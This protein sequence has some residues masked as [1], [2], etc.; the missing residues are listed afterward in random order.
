MEG[1]LDIYTKVVLTIIATALSV[2]ALR[3]AGV[4]ALAQSS[5]FT[6]VLICGGE[7]NPKFEGQLGCASI[8]TDERGFGRVL[9]T[10]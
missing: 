3:D 10:Q 6:K 2:I 7:A 5:G 9:V 8:L 4:P 1:Y